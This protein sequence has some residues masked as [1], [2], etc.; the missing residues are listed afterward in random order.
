MRDTTIRLEIHGWIS[1]GHGYT[2]PPRRR[3][4]VG[5]S[6][7]LVKRGSWVRIP[8]SAWL[9]R[10]VRGRPGLQVTHIEVRGPV[11]VVG[12]QVRGVGDEDDEAPV[13]RKLGAVGVVV[14]LRPRDA[15]RTTD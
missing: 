15:G 3:S 8:S 12:S 11:A 4:S 14:A 6:T 2:R 9:F 1:E 7:A 10:A 5:Q 13:A